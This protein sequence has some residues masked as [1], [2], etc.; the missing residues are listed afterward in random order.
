MRVSDISTNGHAL[1][2]WWLNDVGRAFYG[3]LGAIVEHELDVLLLD[4]SHLQ[5]G[6]GVQRLCEL[7][8]RRGA[9]V[10]W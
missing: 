6:R 4:R 5:F 8:P 9:P 1:K 7:G 10:E 2:L 3:V